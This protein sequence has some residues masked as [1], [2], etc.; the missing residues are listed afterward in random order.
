MIYRTNTPTNTRMCVCVCVL[1]CV[2]VFC[3]CFVC[4]YTRIHMIQYIHRYRGMPRERKNSRPVRRLSMPTPSSCGHVTSA[5]PRLSRAIPTSSSRN[6]IYGNIRECVRARVCVRACVCM[7]MYIYTY[8]HT[9]IHGRISA[10]S[11]LSCKLGNGFEF[12]SV[13]RCS[14]DTPTYC[15]R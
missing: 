1:K 9:W 10:S 13:P 3:M 14:G 6:Y 5:F 12:M 7:Y 2:C 11:D 4:V 15:T 8:T